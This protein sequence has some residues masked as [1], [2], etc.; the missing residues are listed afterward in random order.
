M[1]V[2]LP[3]FIPILTS[4]AQRVS[5]RSMEDLLG[6]G[7]GLARALADT[8]SVVG[9]DGVLCLFY[10]SLL[11]KACVVE[12]RDTP[13]LRAPEDV[14]GAAWASI[15]LDAIRILSRQ[16]PPQAKVLA[17]FAGP[18]LLLEELSSC[19]GIRGAVDSDYASDVFL[20]MIRAAFEAGAKG[21]AIAEKRLDEVSQET[22]SCYRSAFKLAEFYEGLS[23]V[24]HLP[25]TAAKVG[26]VQ[27]HGRFLLDGGDRGSRLVKAMGPS[28]TCLSATTSGDVDTDLPLESLKSLREEAMRCGG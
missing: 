25:G 11:A 16:L 27:A 13:S 3:K 2:A 8:Q 23:L 6:S 15:L 4:Y 12:S 26:E 10:P 7:A 1:P 22:A 18:E 21:I 20:S 9:H 14:V 19:R 24:F 5:G 28:G 17:S